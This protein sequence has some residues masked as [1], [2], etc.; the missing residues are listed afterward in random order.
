[1]N[2]FY[3]FSIAQKHSGAASTAP[4]VNYQKI[5]HTNTNRTYFIVASYDSQSCD[6]RVDQVQK[7][8]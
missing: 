4:H 2:S 6:Y 1:M 3:T 7:I 5:K 8:F